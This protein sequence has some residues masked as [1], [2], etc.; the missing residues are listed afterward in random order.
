MDFSR[1][2]WK[3]R[4]IPFKKLVVDEKRTI[5]LRTLL[6]IAG[7]SFESSNIDNPDLPLSIVVSWCLLSVRLHDNRDN[8]REIVSVTVTYVH[9]NVC[10]HR[11]TCTPKDKIINVPQLRSASNLFEPK[12]WNRELNHCLVEVV[13]SSPLFLLFCRSYLVKWFVKKK[14]KKNRFKEPS[15]WKLCYWVK[16]FASPVCFF[17]ERYALSTGHSIWCVHFS[18]I[19]AILRSR[20]RIFN[21]GS[22]HCPVCEHQPYLEFHGDEKMNESLVP[23]ENRKTIELASYAVRPSS[24]KLLPFPTSLQGLLPGETS[25]VMA[26]V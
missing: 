14:K 3:L 25:S 16:L 12:G 21:F 17:H 23:G 6:P 24:R 8:E 22:L 5:S 11:S 19:P 2:S 18:S 7:F 26:Q 15:L 9:T 10:P 13:R 20:Q 4:E 1:I